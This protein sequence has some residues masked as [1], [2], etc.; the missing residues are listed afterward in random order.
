MLLEGSLRFSSPA[1]VMCPISSGAIANRNL[2]HFHGV[3][4]GRAKGIVKIRRIRVTVP[5]LRRF[6]SMT[7]RP[8]YRKPIQTQAMIVKTVAVRY[9]SC[10]PVR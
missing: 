5:Y 10:Q 6:G 2:G 8:G 4:L 7:T 1:G 9:G 3:D